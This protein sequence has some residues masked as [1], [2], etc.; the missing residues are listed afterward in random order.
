MMPSCFAGSSCSSQR[1]SQFVLAAAGRAKADNAERRATADPAADGDAR[2]RADH[3]LETGDIGLRPCG[4]VRQHRPIGRA[5]Q[6]VERRR[7]IEV[8]IFRLAVMRDIAPR[9]EEAVDGDALFQMFAVVPAVEFGFVGRPRYPSTV[10]S[11]P[12]PA[13]GICNNSLSGDP[14]SHVGNR[15]H[16]RVAHAGIVQ[17]MA[18]ALDD[19]D[20]GLEPYRG[21]R[22]RCR[23]RA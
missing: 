10:S 20:F 7:G 18:G 6:H 15:F 13:I 21:Q 22:V 19:T 23:G 2:D 1:R 16:H 17:R 3:I 4:L 9:F 11:M 8:E 14:R 12:F 5:A